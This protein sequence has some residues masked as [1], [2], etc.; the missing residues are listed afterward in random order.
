MVSLERLAINERMN[1][2]AFTH[3]IKLEMLDRNH[4]RTMKRGESLSI[5]L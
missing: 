3:V 4:A 2:L 1:A 5:G